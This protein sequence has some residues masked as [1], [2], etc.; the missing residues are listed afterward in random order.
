MP[1]SPKPVV[2]RTGPATTE[3]T[4]VRP[5]D[6]TAP[7]RAQNAPTAKRIAVES[8]RIAAIAGPLLVAVVTRRPPPAAV[9]SGRGD[10]ATGESGDSS[11]SPSALSPDSGQEALDLLAHPVDLLRRHVRIQRQGQGFP[12]RGDGPVHP[13]AHPMRHAPEEGLLMNRRIEVAPG[14]DPT[15]REDRLHRVPASPRPPR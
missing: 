11:A 14:L 1:I 8:P 6:T 5:R 10:G 13:V 9:R 2:P 15:R 7:T 4:S 3:E 12:A